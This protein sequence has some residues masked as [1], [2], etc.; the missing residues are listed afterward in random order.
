MG[1]IIKSTLSRPMTAATKICGGGCWESWTSF[2][3]VTP[4][5]Y[6]AISTEARGVL[7][8]SM[9]V[10][11]VCMPSLM[12]VPTSYLKGHPL[13]FVRFTCQDPHDLAVELFAL[14]TEAQPA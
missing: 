10:F 8:E 7:L 4:T 12:F 9:L 1:S 5:N 14:L 13:V 6:N 11:S 3:D 2:R